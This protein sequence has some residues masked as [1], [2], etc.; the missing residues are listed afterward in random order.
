M[1]DTNIDI[2]KIGL[3]LS[4]RGRH[5]IALSDGKTESG[6]TVY[7]IFLGDPEKEENNQTLTLT[8]TELKELKKM[9]N[10]MTDI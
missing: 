3:L 2:K 5:L 9:L 1:S 7:E 8:S 6:A 4:Q 10:N